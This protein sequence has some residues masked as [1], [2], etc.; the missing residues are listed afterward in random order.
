LENATADNPPNNANQS[1]IDTAL[2]AAD[3]PPDSE[4]SDDDTDD[5]T[6]KEDKAQQVSTE[7]KAKRRSTRKAPSSESNQQTH[8]ETTTGDPTMKPSKAARKKS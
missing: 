8:P 1:Q 6:S 3:V 5:L 4:N 7:L 2:N